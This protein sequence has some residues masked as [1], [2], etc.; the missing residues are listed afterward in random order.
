MCSTSTYDFTYMCCWTTQQWILLSYEE[1]YHTTCHSIS[2][3][4]KI[5]SGILRM[6][7]WCLCWSV[8]IVQLAWGEEFTVLLYTT[9]HRTYNMTF[10]R[11]VPLKRNIIQMAEEG[12]D[13]FHRVS[14]SM[15]CSHTPKQQNTLCK[16]FLFDWYTLLWGKGERITIHTSKYRAAVLLL[17][18]FL[19]PPWGREKMFCF[20]RCP[21]KCGVVLPGLVSERLKFCL[22]GE[23][24]WEFTAHIG[25]GEQ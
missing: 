20:G 10:Q 4:V 21:L 3:S 2:S 14:T 12:G 25:V 22:L 1:C 23:S 15:T 9:T 7:L 6:S 16:G 8:G 18:K 13:I 19:F 24:M 5:T 11:R 17:W